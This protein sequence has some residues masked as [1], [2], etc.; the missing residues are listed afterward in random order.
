M[1]FY[2]ICFSQFDGDKNSF[3]LDEGFSILIAVRLIRD[4]YEAFIEN[5]LTFLISEI[6]FDLQNMGILGC[7][8]YWPLR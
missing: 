5:Y 7:P 2:S 8:Y 4:N 3:S 6:L 1:I